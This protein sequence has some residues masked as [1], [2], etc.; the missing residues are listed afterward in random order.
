MNGFNL[1]EVIGNVGNV[2]FGETNSGAEAAT[3]T[4]AIQK[5]DHVTWVRINVYGTGLV[6]LC[7]KN[8]KKGDGVQVRGELMNRKVAGGEQFITEIRCHSINLL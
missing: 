6:D 7:R 1:V 3:F 5:I 2:S 8:I 4:L